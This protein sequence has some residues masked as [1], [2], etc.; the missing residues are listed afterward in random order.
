MSA[1]DLAPIHDS[2]TGPRRWLA[3]LGRFWFDEAPAKRLAVLRVLV[4]L[5]AFWQVG[6]RYSMLAEIARGHDALFEPV[7]AA[8]FLHAPI[9]ATVFELVTV[10][11]P[12][13]PKAK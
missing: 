7:G 13:T 2:S 1:R 4:G 12:F 9:S 5:Y 3:G 8:A 10:Y 11:R 6:S